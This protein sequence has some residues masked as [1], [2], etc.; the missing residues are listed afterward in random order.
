MFVIKP[1]I[2]NTYP[3]IICAV[4]TM[5]GSNPA[6]KYRFNLSLNVGD[7][8]ERVLENREVFFNY[9][10]FSTKDAVL[11]NQIHS[12][13]IKVVDSAGNCAESDALITSKYSLLLVLTVA[14]CIP[15]LIYDKLNHVIAAVHSG[16]RG[17]ESSILKKTLNKMHQLFNSV[18]D[19]LIVYL[20]PSISQL[21]YEVGNEVA[22]KFDNKYK[23]ISSNKIYLDIAALNYNTL[24]DFGVK[25]VNIQ[26]SVL[27]T[28]QMKDLLHS[29]RRDG[30]KSGRAFAVIGMR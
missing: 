18:G 29:F 11:Q 4:S 13:I 7:K 21:S 14:D 22:V 6:D 24:T 30:K 17:A 20:G 19:N 28:Y 23:L 8:K 15:I 12:D 1:Y 27:C 25:P 16:W 26:K 10:G 5:I 2:F 9:L 3:Q